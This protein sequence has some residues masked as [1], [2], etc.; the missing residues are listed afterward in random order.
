MGFRSPVIGQFWGGKGRRPVVKYWDCQSWTV[1]KYGWSDQDTVWDE[2]SAGLKIGWLEFNVPFQHKYDYIR[3]E[4]GSKE[5]CIRWGVHIGATGTWQISQVAA[6]VL[7]LIL[8][9][10]L[11]QPKFR[12]ALN[13]YWQ[14]WFLYTARNTISTLNYSTIVKCSSDRSYLWSESSMCDGDAAFC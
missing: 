6:N 11:Q 4:A 10:S 1:Q 14:T 7:H 3:D 12:H 8:V 9:G 2:D 13:L 5:A